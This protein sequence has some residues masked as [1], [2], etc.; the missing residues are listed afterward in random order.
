MDPRVA[1]LHLTNTHLEASF[2]DR[3]ALDLAAWLVPATFRPPAVPNAHLHYD[4]GLGAGAAG[5]A[6]ADDEA[7]AGGS[8]PSF[9]R[10]EREGTLRVAPKRLVAGMGGRAAPSARWVVDAVWVAIFVIVLGAVGWAGK[11]LLLSR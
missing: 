1:G 4:G 7:S 5:A 3:S 9:V 11:Q 8:D 6:A 2:H 10:V